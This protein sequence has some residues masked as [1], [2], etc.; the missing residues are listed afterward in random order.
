MILALAFMP[1]KFLDDEGNPHANSPEVAPEGRFLPAV[2][3]LLEFEGSEGSW[4]R[5]PWNKKQGL[6]PEQGK[7][8][9]FAKIRGS[10][11][12]KDE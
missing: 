11:V 6:T 10:T 2:V 1:R 12:E 4:S 3:G 9:V 8:N 7:T 5:E